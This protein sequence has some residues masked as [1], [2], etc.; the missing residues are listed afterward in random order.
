VAGEA[1]GA[2]AGNLSADH[3][4]FVASVKARAVNAVLVDFVGEIFALGFV[5]AEAGEKFRGAGEETDAADLMT[6][7]LCKHGFDKEASAAGVLMLRI[8]GDGTDFG[9]VRTVEM[10]RAAADDFR[11]AVFTSAVFAVTFKNDEVTDVFADFGKAAREKSSISG[12]IGDETVDVL[13][14]G[15]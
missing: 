6:L 14:V 10:E 12:V 5:E 11:V 2:V 9:E 7:G 4:D 13:G 1:C 15:E 8:D 3:G